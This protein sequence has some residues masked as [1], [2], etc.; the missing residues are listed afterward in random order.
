MTNASLTLDAS[1]RNGVPAGRAIR[2]LTVLRLKRL[3]NQ[4]IYGRRLGGG[5]GRPA[6]PGKKRNR[7]VV[8]AVAALFMLFAYGNIARQSIINLHQVLDPGVHSR[9][10]TPSGPMSDALLRG[11]TMEWSLLFIAV[12]LLSLA[13]RELSQPDWDLEWLVTLPLRMPVLLWGRVIERSLANPIGLLTLFPAGT[14]IAWISGFRWSAPLVGA[15]GI[16]PLLLLAALFRTLVD[17]GLRLTLAPSR[18]RNLQAVLSVISIIL[19][20]LVISLG[21]SS[22]MAFMLDWARDF[23]LGRAGCRRGSSCRQ[24]MRRHSR[25]SWPWPL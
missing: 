8:S 17:T 12:I 2:L 3:A 16:L 7:W 22:P 15:I 23:P 18:L 4:M 9:F 5:R 10:S 20:Y 11:L 13:A 14:L 21:L 1:F 24:S 6:T 19:L 25:S